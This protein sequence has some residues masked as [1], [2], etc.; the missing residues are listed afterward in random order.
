MRLLH[1]VLRTVEFLED[2]PHETVAAFLAIARSRTLPRDHV[3]WRPGQTQDSIVIPLDGEL[4]ALGRDPG[5]RGICYAFF[6]TG[7]CAGVPSVIDAKP[8]P[9]EV[10]VIRQG[11]F[12]FVERAAFTRF[13]DSH[14]SVRSKVVGMLSS[15]LRKSLDERDRVVFLPVQARVAR[16]LLERACV[17]RSDGA[18]ILLRETQPEIAIRLGSVREVIAREMGALG[19]AGIVRRTRH[20]LFVLDWDRLW[21]KAECARSEDTGCTCEAET[22][23]VRTRRFF[24]PALAHGPNAVADETKVCAE[25]VT[26]FRA[27]VARGCPLAL[28]AHG[29]SVSS[30][31]ADAPRAERSPAARTRPAV[32]A[33]APRVEPPAAC[34]VHDPAGLPRGPAEEEEILRRVALYRERVA[35]IESRFGREDG[36]PEEESV[37]H[38]AATGA[39]AGS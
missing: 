2:E 31:A 9:R 37:F 28:A 12:L 16:F 13:L 38:G 6:G 10:R 29:P 14:A 3:L 11:E 23:V 36:V 32:P 25:S 8:V 24:L 35:R 22:A 20:A 30:E 15:L 19:D 5:G 4:A 34:R 33:A 18:R 21:E 17:R 26:G 7:E 27:C 39:R 1:D